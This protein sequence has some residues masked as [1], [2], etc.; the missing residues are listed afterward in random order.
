MA[1][2]IGISIE[3]NE[4]G[5]IVAKRVGDGFTEAARRIERNTRE[6][7]GKMNVGIGQQ[8]DALT[9]KMV[10]WGAL[11]GVVFGGIA[12]RAIT[13]LGTEFQ[14]RMSAVGAFANATGAEFDQLRSQALALGEA[15]VFTATNAAEAMEQLGLAGF[16]TTE[17]LQVMPNVLSLAAAGTLSMADAAQISS[18]VM[19]QMGLDASG[20]SKAVDTLAFAAAES[21]TTVSELGT[22]FSYAGNV[23]RTLGLKVEDVAS[24]LA[25]LANQGI[26]GERAGTGLVRILSV[27]LGKTEEGEKGLAKFNLKLFDQKGAFVGLA[28]AMRRMQ[29]AGLTTQDVMEGFG[30]RGGPTMLALMNAGSK[31]LDDFTEKT[32]GAGGVAADMAK[33]LRDNLAGD[34]EQATGALQTLAITMFDKVTPA[35]RAVTQAAAEMGRGW[36][37]LIQGSDVLSGIERAAALLSVTLGVVLVN[38]ARRAALALVEMG[39]AVTA[40]TLRVVAGYTALDVALLRNIGLMDA[41]ALASGRA[42]LAMV[43]L[44]AGVFTISYQAT[45]AILELTGLDAAIEAFFVRVMNRGE[46]A[47]DVLRRFNDSLDLIDK[48]VSKLGTKGIDLGIDFGALDEVRKKV[49][50]LQKDVANRVSMK[51]S[52]KDMAPFVKAL[53]TAQQQSHEL[54]NLSNQFGPKFTVAWKQAADGA[55]TLED[56]IAKVKELL[57]TSGT[58]A[59]TQAGGKVDEEALKRAQQAMK[60]FESALTQSGGTSAKILSDMAARFT[61]LGAIA[62]KESVPL[63]AFAQAFGKDLVAAAAAAQKAGLEIPNSLRMIIE[64][65]K[66]LQDVD[67]N[68]AKNKDALESLTS[69]LLTVGFTTKASVDEFMANWDRMATVGADIPAEQRVAAFRGEILK[70]AKAAESAGIE[71]SAFFKKVAADAQASL[72]GSKPFLDERFRLETDVTM[73]ILEFNKQATTQGTLE[74]LAAENAIELAGFDARLAAALANEQLTQDE[75]TAIAKAG[76]Q[77]R[78][79][80]EGAQAQTAVGFSKLASDSQLDNYNRVAVG[81]A[82]VMKSIFG[83]SKAAAYASAIVNTSAGVA[84]S[85]KEGGWLGI[86]LAVIV[87]AAGLVEISKIRSTNLNYAAEGGLITEGLKRFEST[88]IAPF[89]KPRGTDTVPAML[90]PGERVLTVTDTRA[91]QSGQIVIAARSTREGRTPGARPISGSDG[92]LVAIPAGADSFAR[93]AAGGIVG[94]IPEIHDSVMKFGRGG[95]ALREF[96]DATVS[97]NLRHDHGATSPASYAA[98]GAVITRGPTRMIAGEAGPEA[99]VPLSGAPARRVAKAMGLG[100]GGGESLALT[101]NVMGDNWRDSGIADELLEKIHDGLNSLIRRGRKQSFSLRTA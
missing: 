93:F 98:D 13:R 90:T 20:F 9:T 55:K 52:D 74:R 6:S 5:T 7:F 91:V 27:M 62:T 17:I 68:T 70:L 29:A 25:L 67:L 79:G 35:L 64:E 21:T 78:A 26:Q 37:D 8:L 80:I 72:E 65:A 1:K 82:A 50:Q 94:D 2:R 31:A 57:Q 77:A 3:V 15:T 38:A 53:A 23:A 16:K 73:Q 88:A 48:T 12:L 81:A 101:L 87:G 96:F 10:R 69:E 4:N 36:S 49:Q 92:S 32:K 41:W 95:V 11:A 56:R 100:Q 47:P 51:F 18:N 83:H 71:T 75:R 14:T 33:K 43:G 30:Q 28:E 19:R 60:E 86:A 54:L 85:L 39:V 42:R 89:F 44:A 63:S 59:P 46:E 99:I 40:S 84:A 22:A 58:A 24:A 97:D 66:K 34:A 76:A 45:R 61:A